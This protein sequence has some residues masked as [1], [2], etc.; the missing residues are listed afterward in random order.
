[1]KKSRSV[2]IIGGG[3]GGVYT[4]KA[5]L[6]RRVPVTLVSET[7]FFTFTPLLHE[8]ATG[9]LTPEDVTFEYTSF[10]RD[11]LFSFVRGRGEDVKMN[12]RTFVVDGVKMSYETLVLATGATT[13]FYDLV[14]RE[15]AYELKT[16]E[17]AKRLKQRLIELGQGAHREVVVT[18][19][20]GGPTGIELVFEMELFLRALAERQSGLRYS[21][22]VVQLSDTVL[23]P[24]PKK[25]QEHTLALL[26][27]RGIEVWLNTSV[28]EVREQEVV[29]SRGVV[30]SQLTVMA[31]GVTPCV[32]V[33]SKNEPC[34]E[35][36]HV[37]VDDTLRVRGVD[38]VY[39][40]GDVIAIGGAP[41]PKLAQLATRQGETVA[42]N[43]VRAWEGQKLQVYTPA[44]KGLLV[45]L[46]FRE[47]AGAVGRL[48]ILGLPAWFLWRTV[49]LFKTPGL[50]NKLRV[51]FSWTLGLFQKRNLS[52]W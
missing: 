35:R 16:V 31:A 24:F 41:T 22:R 7:N 45:S 28:S 36:G 51:A 42:E 3:F 6:K 47:G 44:V 20:G 37:Q 32:E 11:P 33:L 8:V 4:A 39:A 49:Y 1:M 25:I 40:L 10:F 18:V 29:T 23:G 12:E 43:I 9:L 46:G 30:P 26:K 52:E 21:I 15:W 19:V 13:A 17:D 2:T 14:G 27:K 50:W 38:H 48:I 5:L 34:I